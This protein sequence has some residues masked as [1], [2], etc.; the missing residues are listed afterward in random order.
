M[1]MCIMITLLRKMIIMS[2]PEVLSKFTTTRSI[3]GPQNMGMFNFPTLST[4]VFD[5]TTVL[6]IAGYA[7]SGK[8]TIA[9]YI[10]NQGTFIK[11][12]FAKPLYDMLIA[13]YDG[14]V[15][16]K[17]TYDY[18]NEHK[19]E[20][21]PYTDVTWRT[22]LQKL[23]TEFGRDCLHKDVWARLAMQRAIG[24]HVVISDCRFMN[25]FTQFKNNSLFSTYLIYV[26]RKQA[27]PQTHHRSEQEIFSLKANA[28]YIVDNNKLLTKTF[29][30]VDGIINDIN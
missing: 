10:V 29:S 6:L 19:N 17:I 3:F 11:D 8:D 2:K 15:D 28:D 4:R 9:D 16:V 24:K 26:D 1:V 13:I 14:A 18:I 21:M 7:Q 12:K 5:K 30:I 23:G 22:A 20:F 27:Q 25:E